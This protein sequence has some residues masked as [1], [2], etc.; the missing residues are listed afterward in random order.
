M[1]AIPS[2]ILTLFSRTPVHLGA[3]NSVGAIDSPIMRER[4]TRIPVIPGSSLKGVLADLWSD[5]QNMERDHKDNKLKRKL[6][7]EAAWLFG[8]EGRTSEESGNAGDKE[9]KNTSTAGALLIGESR[10]LVFPVR[11]AKGSFA[12]IT[13]PLALSRFKRDT[14]A[15][16]RIPDNLEAEECYASS[17]VTLTDEKDKSKK[18]I[19]EEYCL[20]CKGESDLHREIQTIVDDDVWKDLHKRFVIVSDEMFSYFVEQSCEVVTRIRIDDE[21]GVVAD[22]AL[23][24][25]E[26]VP[27]ETLFYTIV[28]AQKEKNS[29]GVA[30]RSADEALDVLQK[31]LEDI[32]VIQLGGDETIGLGFC[33]ISINTLPHKQ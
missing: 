27:S 19:L 16:F 14:Q 31:E 32:E 13:C 25:Q 26:N 3:G 24:N 7:S 18:I 2:R 10:V 33:S 9:N 6:V 5:D 30:A 21:T 17:G 4:H 8:V 15:A 20:K 29:K 12:W 23:F 28:S 1:S 22:G 11:S